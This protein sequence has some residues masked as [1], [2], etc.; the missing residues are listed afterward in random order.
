MIVRQ[1]QVKSPVTT[2]QSIRVRVYYEDTDAGG[3]VYYANYLRYFERARS[4]WLRAI[5]I[6]HQELSQQEG[7]SLVVREC[8]VQ[9]LRPARLD[10]LLT[11]DV[12][13]SDPAVD[14]RRAS[15]RFTQRAVL[16]NGATGG[17]TVDRGTVLATGT[18]RV[19]C[20]DVRTGK[21]VALPAWLTEK[22]AALVGLN[23]GC[24]QVSMQV[25]TQVPGSNEF[26]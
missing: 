25:L 4:D 10:D 15:M 22:V 12:G 11:V 6:S 20:V 7:V 13:L 9:Y 3:I 21:P 24:K 8:A 14:I 2:L 18:V 5:G 16:D 17:G 26:K 1:G 23:A 19:A